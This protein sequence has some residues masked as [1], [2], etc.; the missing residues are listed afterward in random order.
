MYI[1]PTRSEQILIS[2]LR[3]LLGLFQS[4]YFRVSYIHSK[5]RLKLRLCNARI[6]TRKGEGL[7]HVVR[8]YRQFGR[9]VKQM[10]A[11]SK[12][13]KHLDKNP[14]AFFIS[15][16]IECILR[17]ICVYVYWWRNKG[18]IRSVRAT[19][20]VLLCILVKTPCKSLRKN[21]GKKWEHYI[22]SIYDVIEFQF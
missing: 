11:I 1:C 18:C 17:L 9:H 13:D 22:K 7:F 2:S 20:S 6:L 10:K 16:S 8:V 15:F 19:S 14:N 5:I 12:L 4:I 21:S 3:C